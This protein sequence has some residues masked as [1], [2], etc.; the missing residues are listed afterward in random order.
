MNYVDLGIRAASMSGAVS[1]GIE[2]S[3]LSDS[4]DEIVK[5]VSVL[6]S[7]VF[8]FASFVQQAATFVSK[9]NSPILFFTAVLI[10]LSVKSTVYLFDP[11]ASQWIDD[12]LSTISHLAALVS[13]VSLLVLGVSFMSFAGISL[14][15]H[16]SALILQG[17]RKIQNL[18][19]ELD[20]ER[21]AIDSPD[22]SHQALQYLREALHAELV[23]EQDMAPSE[24]AATIESEEQ[25]VFAVSNTSF[26][27]YV[28]EHCPQISKEEACKLTV[29]G[30]HILKALLDRAKVDL[31]TNPSESVAAIVWALMYDAVKSGKGFEEG[32]WD[33]PDTGDFD[34]FN[35]L[36]SQEG[37]HSRLSSHYKGRVTEEGH[38]GL[39]LYK[40]DAE[41]NFIGYLL[42]AS[43]QTIVFAKIRSQDGENRFYLKP[44]NFGVQTWS[45]WLAHAYE[46]IATRPAHF[47]GD[48]KG[49]GFRKEH[50][51]REI[52]AKFQEIF[53]QLKEAVP[54]DCGEDVQANLP[55]FGIGFIYRFLQ[56]ASSNA[57][58]QE[59]SPD[60]HFAICAFMQELLDKY[61][62][63]VEGRMGEEVFC[64]SH[65]L[66]DQRAFIGPQ[67]LSQSMIESALSQESQPLADD[68]EWSSIEFIADPVALP[69]QETEAVRQL[70]Q[71]TYLGYTTY[72]PYFEL[73][74]LQHTCQIVD[75]FLAPGV[76]MNM[77]EAIELIIQTP[78]ANLSNGERVIFVPLALDNPWKGG[79]VDSLF[80]RVG[81][82]LAG[83]HA[84][85]AMI[86]LSTKQIE[87]YDSQGRHGGVEERILLATNG[88]PLKD[89]F[90]AL[91]ECLGLE[92]IVSSSTVH[93]GN[94]DK[95][96]CGVFM[97]RTLTKRLGGD[98]FGEI[99]IPMQHSI[100]TF[101][102][103]VIDSMQ[104]RE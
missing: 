46:Y 80:N 13:T 27:S 34:L 104:E 28:E 59:K 100:D 57:E 32:T 23:I 99:K 6:A 61:E 29:K 91:Q 20:Q 83:G 11:E 58:I 65:W 38:F 14:A 49:E 16:S 10:P 40:R 19:N 68:E 30:K 3:N 24:G 44:E 75:R 95:R 66:G 82:P 64:T 9:S 17:L 43:K 77:E 21:Q 48:T 71:R 50:L 39:D 96:N 94:F 76:T 37:A 89:L 74:Q 69:S 25:E 67:N 70:K 60:L 103:Q 18:Q 78:P 73:L 35:F 4:R 36:R 5:K 8:T 102:D 97:M 87:Y 90:Q 12:R 2:W 62:D 88:I 33:V 79:W 42:P 45:H 47:W 55:V 54:S 7:A 85:L 86:N 41:G 84:V 101:R 56:S 93:Q 22:S 63:S 52:K 53:S 26:I 92:G 81:L 15:I 31:E 98:S 1:V 72:A 51:P